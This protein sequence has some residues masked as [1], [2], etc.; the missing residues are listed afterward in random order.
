MLDGDFELEREINDR[1]DG[2]VSVPLLFGTAWP[3][4]PAW[5]PCLMPF[6][7]HRSRDTTWTGKA[8]LNNTANTSD[9]HA[10]L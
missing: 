8:V 10:R 9:A 5:E 1:V 7:A 6:P 4:R 2:N 3:A